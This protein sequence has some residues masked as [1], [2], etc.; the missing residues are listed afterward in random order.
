MTD[1]LPFAPLLTKPIFFHHSFPL[2]GQ[3]LKAIGLKDAAES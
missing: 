3:F 2:H 1:F